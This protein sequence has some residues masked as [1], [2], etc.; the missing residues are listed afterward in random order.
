MD[1]G[2]YSTGLGSGSVGSGTPDTVSSSACLYKFWRHR[3]PNWFNRN[4][5]GRRVGWSDRVWLGV[6]YYSE[7]IV[8]QAYSTVKPQKRLWPPFYGGK[9]HKAARGRIGLWLCFLRNT[10]K[11]VFSHRPLSGHGPSINTITSYFAFQL[12]VVSH[13]ASVPQ[14]SVSGI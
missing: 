12:L 13:D 9:Y 8:F 5:L 14:F 1:K 11:S 10:R 3:E 2:N 4:I 6:L 7:K